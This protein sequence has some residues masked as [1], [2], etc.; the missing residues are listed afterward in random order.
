[1]ADTVRATVSAPGAEAAM[2]E[3]AVSEPAAGVAAQPE[4]TTTTRTP[5]T[6]AAVTA[7]ASA[8]AP[9]TP[10]AM[11]VYDALAAAVST[12]QRRLSETVSRLVDVYRYSTG[13]GYHGAAVWTPQAEEPYANETDDEDEDEDGDEDGDGDENEYSDDRMDDE[14]D[15]DDLDE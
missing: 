2:V 11:A 14:D 12:V 6:T 15:E 4:T 13:A 8:A 1:M 3:C 7:T 5:P 10:K 9:A